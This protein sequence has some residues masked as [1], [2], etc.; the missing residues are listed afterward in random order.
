M[1][2][3]RPKPEPDATEPTSTPA[4]IPLKY[5]LS[6]LNNVAELGPLGDAHQQA[7]FSKT[8]PRAKFLRR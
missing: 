6:E 3:N 7:N 5:T 8:L 4:R 1:T 2:P